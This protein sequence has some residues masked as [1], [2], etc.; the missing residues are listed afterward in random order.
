MTPRERTALTITPCEVLEIGPTQLARLQKL[1]PRAAAQIL[2]GFRSHFVYKALKTTPFFSTLPDLTHREAAPLFDVRLLPPTTPTRPPL[3]RQGEPGHEM[4]I[5]LW[6]HVQIV[7]K[8]QGGTNSTNSSSSSSSHSHSH[9]H[10]HSTGGGGGGDASASSSPMGARREKRGSRE[11]AEEVLLCEYTAR[12]AFPWLGEVFLWH[13]DHARSGE[14]RVL[15]ES[16]VLSL[17]RANVEA[18]VRLI[19]GFR[20]LAMTNASTQY[21][22]PIRAVR[23]SSRGGYLAGTSAGGAHGAGGAGGKRTELSL[24]HAIAWGRIVGLLIGATYITGVGGWGLAVAVKLEEVRH[25][26]QSSQM[27][28]EW[29][30]QLN[31]QYDQ[32]EED[33][34]LLKRERAHGTIGKA[35]RAKKDY[36]E[37]QEKRKVSRWTITRASSSGMSVMKS[38]AEMQRRVAEKQVR[39]QAEVEASLMK[40]AFDAAPGDGRS[41][42]SSASSPRLKGWRGRWPVKQQVRAEKLRQWAEANPHPELRRAADVQG[43]AW[44]SR[45]TELPDWAQAIDNSN[46]AVEETA[47]EVAERRRKKAAAAAAAQADAGLLQGGGREVDAAPTRA[48]PGSKT[49]VTMENGA[50]EVDATIEWGSVPR[51]AAPE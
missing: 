16:L 33:L 28:V 2:L 38:V 46:L 9:S 49:R 34:A 6:G 37:A 45:E 27:A 14:A 21:T 40:G 44:L 17:P 4:Y 30:T 32:E 20:A 18:F 41:L 11:A 12:S 43:S 19:P 1:S 8:G 29:A 36:T 51:G 48:A 7:C 35:V 23:L 13:N 31:A 15:Q 42:A 3:F 25:Q 47:A 10:S 39:L 26:K 22:I 5:M 24:R 50:G